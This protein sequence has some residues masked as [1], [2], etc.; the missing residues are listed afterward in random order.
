MTVQEIRDWL[1]TQ[2]CEWCA[3]KD[4][5]TFYDYLAAKIFKLIEK[6]KAE[7]TNGNRTT[8]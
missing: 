2:D 8:G 7:S 3:S 5:R 1:A 6:E 4:N